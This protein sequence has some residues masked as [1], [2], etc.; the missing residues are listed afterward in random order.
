ME[1]EIINL[2]VNEKRS[3]FTI[4]KRVKASI[5][6]VVEVLKKNNIEIDTSDFKIS[7]DELYD[8]YINK[9]LSIEEISIKTNIK[10]RHIYYY[11]Y[12]FEIKKDQKMIFEQIARKTKESNLQK[13]GVEYTGM[14]ESVKEKRKQTNLEKYGVEHPM[15][16]KDVSNK[17]VGRKYPNKKKF[18][19]DEKAIQEK[20]AKT[21]MERYGSTSYLGTEEC[22]RKTKETLMKKYGVEN[23]AQ[24]PSAKE[25]RKQTNLEKYG[26][27]NYKQSELFKER[28][29]DKNEYFHILNDKENFINFL[30]EKE[31][32]LGKKITIIEISEIMNY[33]Q[34]YINRYIKNFDLYDYIECHWTRSQY[35]DEIIEWL[36]SLNI[37]N[38][39]NNKKFG[40]YEID[41]F[42]PD[43]NIGI[44]F[45][46]S[47]WH[48]ELNKPNN[49]HQK[50]YNALKEHN[51][52][53]YN[54]FEYE[55]KQEDLKE[56]IKSQ[57]KNILNLNSR[58]LYARKCIIKEITTDISSDFLDHNHI[59][60]KDSS[61]IKLG[62]F[63]EEELVSV[64]T[65]TKPRFNEN[66]DWELSRFCCL[67]DTTVIGASSKLFKYF[68]KNY[69]GENQSIISY[70]DIG[71]TTGKMY[72][73]LGFKLLRISSPNYVWWKHKNIKSRYQCMM[74]NEIDTMHEAGFIRIFDS[75]NKVW[76]YNQNSESLE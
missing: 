20:I 25:K 60:G 24:I 70:S 32:E 57:L 55:W 42:L 48:S 10:E 35:E 43:Y 30:K 38:I 64:M 74:K 61:K 67:R 5:K 46:G 50:K 33:S 52:F 53:I 6:Y 71:K 3:V 56:K 69:L 19:R 26:V 4:I 1:N 13:Y 59:Q 51:I 12:V 45:N 16:S 37:S 14:L 8:L 73:M 18:V 27:E 21:M 49:Y 9:N 7:Y 66:Y 72:E 62:L 36:T 68:V 75:G 63:Y 58:K 17:L 22:K 40:R 65:F 29:N 47:Y 39:E 11:I 28:Q 34:W 54:V 41:I 15:L 76:V 31:A 44:E 2:F 23:T